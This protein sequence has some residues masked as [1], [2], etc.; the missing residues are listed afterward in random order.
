MT[1]DEEKD[2]QYAKGFVFGVWAS[3]LLS[4]IY[5]MY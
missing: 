3:I 4:L 5:F 2:F 1:R